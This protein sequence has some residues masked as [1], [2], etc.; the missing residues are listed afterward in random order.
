[1]WKTESCSH[2]FWICVINSQ[3]LRVIWSNINVWFVMRCVLNFKQGLSLIIKSLFLKLD[4][5]ICENQDS[6]SWLS[7]IQHSVSILWIKYCDLKLWTPRTQNVF[8]H[9]SH[10]GFK[11]NRSEFSN[12]CSFPVLFIFEGSQ[13]NFD[14]TGNILCWELIDVSCDRIQ[15]V[16]FGSS[17][18][19]PSTFRRNH[20][21]RFRISR[22]SN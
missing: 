14:F 2:V 16:S 18:A 15:I 20:K 11:S 3:H 7:I 13:F 9:L 1:M 8:K 12:S 19:E 6:F 10:W 21:I 17:Y 4:K 22:F 5:L